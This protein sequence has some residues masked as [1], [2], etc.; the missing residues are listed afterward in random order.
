MD[1]KTI[2]HAGDKVVVRSDLAED[3]SYKMQGSTFG[4]LAIN[5]MLN[6]AGKVAVITGVHESPISGLHYTIAGSCWKWSDEMFYGKC[7]DSV[8]DGLDDA[9]TSEFMAFIDWM[10]G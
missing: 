10:V 6:M 9:D 5:D 7:F 8:D 4:L 3:V 1:N 2:Y